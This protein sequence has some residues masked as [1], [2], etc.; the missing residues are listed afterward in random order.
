MLIQRINPSYTILKLSHYTILAITTR[1]IYCSTKLLKATK[2]VK[3]KT[4]S[5]K[6]V[7]LGVQNKNNLV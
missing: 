7:V 1:L 5:T 6:L 2:I 4:T 3:A